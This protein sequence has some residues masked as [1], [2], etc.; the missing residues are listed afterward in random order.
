MSSRSV[1][2]AVRSAIEGK[3]WDVVRYPHTYSTAWH[4]KRALEARPVDAVI[5]VGA[6]LGGFVEML[7]DAVGYD[8][9]ILSFEPMSDNFS[10]LCRNRARDK[11]WSGQNIAIG[12]ERGRL[13][14]QLHNKSDFNSFLSVNSLA[15]DHFQ[16]T[17]SG[18]V[19]V[20]VRRLDEVVDL[21]GTL[22]I[23]SDTQGY[24]L[25]VI[26]GAAGLLDRV[27]ILMIEMSVEPLYYGMPTMSEAIA[28]KPRQFKRLAV[29][30]TRLLEVLWRVEALQLSVLDH[31]DPIADAEGRQ[32]VGDDHDRHPITQFVQRL[33]DQVLAA[34]VEST[35]GLVEDEHIGGFDERPSDDQALLLPAAEVA[36]LFTDLALVALGESPTSSCRFAN[37]AAASICSWVTPSRRNRMLSATVPAIR[38]ACWGTKV[39]SRAHSVFDSSRMSRPAANTLPSVGSRRASSSCTSVDLPLPDGPTTPT[40]SRGSI[41]RSIPRSTGTSSR[42]LEAHVLHRE[43]PT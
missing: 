29:E 42:V 35:R 43:A 15:V 5:D 4:I 20:E 40:I 8:G 14:L 2:R 19:D 23:K 24:D 41:C 27:A 22:M 16:L 21:P 34:N 12:A 39:T 11:R 1:R 32:P 18:T 9:S 37:L 31:H 10:Q 28:A 7:R 36:S 6:H 33:P 3:G 25:K 13:P 30:V 38:C 17:M 26:E